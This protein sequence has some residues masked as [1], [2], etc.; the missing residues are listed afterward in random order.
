MKDLYAD[1]TTLQQMHGGLEVCLLCCT[2]KAD[3]LRTM[4]NTRIKYQISNNCAV[5]LRQ[6]LRVLVEHGKVPKHGYSDKN[7]CT[8]LRVESPVSYRC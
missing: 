3:D 5:T 4:V 7:L 2:A 6:N 1:Y 8:V